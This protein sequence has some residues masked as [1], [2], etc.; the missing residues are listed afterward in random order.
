MAAALILSVF[1][2]VNTL[3]TRY[4]SLPLNVESGDALVP[5]SSLTRMVRVSVRGETN[6]IY[7]ISEGDIE[8][9]ID[10]KKQLIEGSYRIP[11]QIRKRGAALGVEPLEISVDPLEVS[12]RLER[13]LSRDITVIPVYRGKVAE[14]YELAAQSIIPAVVAAEGPRSFVE[15]KSGF[16]TET[17]DLEGRREDFSV[18][19][20]IID[21][22]PFI[23]IHGNRMVEYRG[24][25]RRIMHQDVSVDRGE[26]N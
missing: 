18:I 21:D 24:V 13:N 8:A 1:H 9:Y 14:G 20:S 22:E 3:E 4:F 26:Q 6:S 12:L 25:I 11:V 10:A 15:S 19:L 23:A 2:R 17:I 7:S 16:Q 5:A